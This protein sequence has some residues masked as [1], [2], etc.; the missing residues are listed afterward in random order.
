M[1][2]TETI[3]EIIECFR[4]DVAKG[5]GP[6]TVKIGRGLYSHMRSRGVIVEREFS[7]PAF[8]EEPWVLPGYADVPE[9]F[10]PPD[11]SAPDRDYVIGDGGLSARG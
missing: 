11:S 2:G 1:T 6:I 5:K 9:V 4:R 10:T 3:D 8:P 7:N